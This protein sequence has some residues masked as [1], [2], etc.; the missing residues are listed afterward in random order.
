MKKKSFDL[1]VLAG[2]ARQEIREAAAR[3]PAP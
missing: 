2:A 1:T 3:F